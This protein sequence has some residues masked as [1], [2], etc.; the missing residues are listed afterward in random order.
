M[1][2]GKNKYGIQKRPYICKTGD[3]WLCRHGE[4][5]MGYKVAGRPMATPPVCPI[6]GKYMALSKK[7]K[8][9]G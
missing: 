4:K 6:C 8:S 2:R 9:A 1:D 3:L 5:G 7:A